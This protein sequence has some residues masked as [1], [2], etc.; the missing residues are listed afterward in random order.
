[1][2]Y[3]QYTYD[4]V[5]VGGGGAAALAAVSA[6]QAGATVAIVSKE[7]SLVGGA[8]IMS[9]G[10]TSAILSPGDHS[11]IFFNDMM[12]AGG[13]LNHPGLARRVAERSTKAL[14]DLETY[15]FLLDR[16][17]ASSLRV[18]KQ[19]EGHSWPRGYLD[20]R[21]ALGFCHA[22]SK[23]LMRNEVVLFSEMIAGKLLVKDH[24]A[25]G[26]LAFS[27]ATGKY[28]VFNAKS[29]IL[30]TGGLGALY[31][32]TTNSSLLTGDGYA[33]AWDSGTELVDME[34]VQFLP[35]AFPYPQAR[36]GKIIG[37]CSHF[38]PGVMLYN[39]L[40]ERYMA[41]YDPQRMEFTTR[42]MGSR[43]NFTEIKEGRGTKNHAIIVDPRE[44]DRSIWLRWKTSL[45]YHY[46]MFRQVFGER[47]ADWEEP[48]EAI[49]SQHF[50]MGGVR[51]DDHCRTN[52]AG[53]FAVGEVAGGVHGA[54][55]LS[56][57]ALTEVFVFGP[58]SGEN[59][60]L[61]A[62]TQK[63]IPIL[64][65]EIDSEIDRLESRSSKRERDVK[66]FE[67]K[68]AIQ[69]IMWDQL[70]PVRDQMGIQTAIDALGNIQK[71]DLGH[72]AIGPDHCKYNR[73]RMEAIEVSLMIKTALLLATSALARQES[74]GSHYRTDF[75]L[76]ND[77][78]WLKNI[79][80]TKNSN[81]EVTINVQE[82]G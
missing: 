31:Q 42:D 20:R 4:I 69:K 7:S 40:G 72:M 2:R 57:V 74:R 22:L 30:A 18:I 68:E 64:S 27:V 63:L 16:R 26:V 8:T 32:V 78:E 21:E 56:G 6:R 80:L 60:A 58:L 3:T 70:G 24:Q 79:I 10:G 37:M 77:N 73:E 25:I 76:S 11:E 34:M 50:F 54:N 29:V 13:R 43:A 51:I 59:A 48:F 46:A 75:P 1:M 17:D 45:P 49:P 28:F 14:L 44:H 61:Y 33:M 53:L 55:R 47:A 66:P 82:I 35:L 15:D 41:K 5:I 9:A 39:G 81:G 38:G 71:S 19:G 23:A 67:L 12:Q 52:I 62:N 36:R 65:A